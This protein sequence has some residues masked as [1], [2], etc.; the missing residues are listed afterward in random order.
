MVCKE[1]PQS[2]KVFAFVYYQENRA[3]MIYVLSIDWLSVFCI[4]A[5]N[6]D[7]WQPIR[8]Q[9]FDYKRESFGTRCF[10]V[11]HRARIAN[12]EGGW[13]EFAEIQSVP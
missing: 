3:A 5:G 12:S 10:S 8:N 11:F 2:C 4:Y 9:E 1:F 6:G 13:D 7:E